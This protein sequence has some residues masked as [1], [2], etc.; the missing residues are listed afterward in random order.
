MK[1]PEDCCRYWAVVGR[2]NGDDEDS[3]HTYGP[4]TKDEAIA[5]FKADLIEESCLSDEGVAEIND[6][7][8]GRGCWEP[9]DFPGYINHVF[10]SV[11]RIE[12]C[13]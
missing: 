10:G 5:G 6:E 2:I 13:S 7:I 12:D 4:C 3:G 1:L 8:Y 9:G 11:A